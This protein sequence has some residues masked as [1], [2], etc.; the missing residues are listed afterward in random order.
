MPSNPYLDILK[1]T[2]PAA[3]KKA[4]QSSNPYL[5]L[6]TARA[7][8]GDMPESGPK[9]KSISPYNPETPG[10]DEF[11]TQID[12]P[13]RSPST[14]LLKNFLGSLGSATKIA[15]GFSDKSMAQNPIFGTY[16]ALKEPT[17]GAQQVEQAGKVEKLPPVAKQIAQGL[18]RIFVPGVEKLANQIGTVA[19][20]KGQELPAPM[21]AFLAGGDAG[22]TFASVGAIE[23]VH[24]I[25][26]ETGDVL[27]NK[28]TALV[29]SP[30]DLR[31]KLQN[32]EIKTPQGK[33]MAEQLIKEGLSIKAQG[34]EP[35]GGVMQAVGEKLG[36]KVKEPN[37]KITVEQTGEPI[38]GELG[39]GP[40]VPKP[41]TAAEKLLA[42]Q[43]EL[44]KPGYPARLAAADIK[45][46]SLGA[47]AGQAASYADSG[48]I[49]GLKAIKAQIDQN[50]DKINKDSPTGQEA[51]QLSKAL[52]ESI[53][54]TIPTQL[55]DLAKKAAKFENP[56][57]FV[58]MLYD[59]YQQNGKVPKTELDLN[60]FNEL[61]SPVDKNLQPTQTWDAGAKDFWQKARDKYN[62]EAGK[63]KEQSPAQKQ[64]PLAAPAET[65]AGAERNANTPATSGAT[66]AAEAQ[67]TNA[68]PGS[69][70]NKALTYLQ[71]E[72][73]AM[74]KS[75]LD[76]VQKKY[77]SSNVVSADHAKEAIPDYNGTNSDEYQP[78][79]SKFAANYYDQ[80][81]ETQK[82]KG[83]N[84]VL[85]FAG[86]TG[87]GKTSALK[88]LG[89]Q[90]SKY[91]IVY[92]TNAASMEAAS[93]KID[94]ALANGYKVRVL[95]VLRD[96][97]AAY[98]HGVIPRTAEEGRVVSVDTH[99]Q[100]HKG[101]YETIPQLVKKYGNKIDLKVA[102]NTGPAGQAKLVAVDK[103][104]KI[105]HAENTKEQLYA[106]L[107][108]AQQ[109]NRL[110]KQQVEKAT[111]RLGTAIREQSQQE[112]PSGSGA[113]QQKSQTVSSQATDTNTGSGDSG[114]GS[115]AASGKADEPGTPESRVWER[116]KT[117]VPEEMQDNLAYDPISLKKNAEAAVELVATDKVRAYKIAMGVESPPPGQTQTAVSIALAERALQEKNY[118]LF[119]QITKNRSLTQT[120]RGQ[121]IVSE[122]GS[123]SDN[124]ASRYVKELIKMR[125]ENVAKKYLSNLTDKMLKNNKVNDA[126]KVVDREVQKVKRAISRTKEMDI[127]DA[128]K[129]LDSLACK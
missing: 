29:L 43:T 1:G 122:K 23:T 82:G 6:L 94:K 53:N 123:V 22:I 69:E 103:L 44:A 17:S 62:P 86:G 72:P 28:N 120:R 87:A 41:K 27:V 24:D 76:I 84:T 124:S 52:E 107:Q 21:D 74:Q 109:E 115:F 12:T 88:S 25:L 14:S 5:D 59:G 128:Q 90:T 83:N 31:V 68:G 80:L 40:E 119:A 3:E 10:H 98:E 36:G 78:A 101:S 93:S 99:L 49:V 127:N 111:G 112:Q 125:M 100:T 70:K 81:L 105:S 75:Y 47:I 64:A 19:G 34:P 129:F 77:G 50:L 104:P 57:E 7:D 4:T 39:S 65:G 95:Y 20:S 121:E 55:V 79:A 96:P 92:D 35:R 15:F 2:A 97:V 66:P 61:V 63:T 102:D 126:I 67:P 9:T 91:A 71:T 46:P 108:K 85:I 48:N 30:E 89:E 32:G 118:S 116:L 8:N 73:A 16:K 33:A 58:A 54:R 56:E 110:T 38:A 11:M 26:G 37:P 45:S 113:P 114:P 18:I 106:Q 117:E 42:R 60:N 51:A 13:Q